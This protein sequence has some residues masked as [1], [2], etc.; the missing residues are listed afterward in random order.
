MKS[1]VKLSAVAALGVALVG[2][3][4]KKT[5]PP[6]PSGPSEFA[7]SIQLTASPDVLSQDGRSESQITVIA[8]DPNNQP[9]RNLALRADIVVNGTVVDFGTLSQKHIATG[10]DG[11]A[12]IVYRAPEAVDNV[13]RNT[14]VNITVTPSSGD[15]AGNT[16]RSVSIRLVPTGT[17]GGET[18]VPDF[19]FAPAVPKQLESVT[20]DASSAVL[21]ATLVKYVWDFGDGSKGSGRVASHQFREVGFYTVTLTVTDIMGR[22]G[23]RSKSVGIESSGQPNAA[24]VFSPSAP[25]L[26]EEIVFNA[27]SST[28]IAPRVIVKYEWQFGTDRTGTGMIV[29]KRYDTPGTYHV[30]LKVTDDAGNTGTSSQPVVVG[31]SSPG[32]LSPQFSVSPSD[33]VAGTEVVFNASASTSAS[34]IVKYEWDFGDAAQ[35]P[36]P[37]VTTNARTTW[38][39]ATPG[40]YNVTLR[41]VDAQ[42]RSA[43]VSQEVSVAEP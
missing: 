35:A 20:F 40:T 31:T 21:D 4:T 19:Q 11:R 12:T 43:T 2:C 10:S 24:F 36:T 34:S 25:G 13:D 6:A 37:R 33:P 18:G 23:S 1:I 8:R 26:G 9:L 27:S 30:S 16:A 32:G 7:T 22:T 29:T 38:T 39:F 41:I 5:E 3:T 17:V 42:G 14:T 15:A 28:A